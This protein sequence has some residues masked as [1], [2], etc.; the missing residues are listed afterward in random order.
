MTSNVPF[1]NRTWR[2][3]VDLCSDAPWQ[4]SVTVLYLLLA[5]LAEGIGF[6]TLLPVLSAATG[7]ATETR[8][9]LE[10]SVINVFGWLGLSTDLSTLLFV[11]V[12]G[13]AGK[14]VLGLL[15]MRNLGYAS[16]DMATR[17]RV[18]LIRSLM[19][20]NWTYFVSQ[21]TGRLGNAISNEASQAA[22]AY[23]AVTNL[24]ST[25]IQ[26]SI[27]SCLALLASWQV[28]VVGLLAGSLMIIMLNSLVGVARAAGA[29]QTSLMNELVSRLSDVLSL[30]K[31]LKAMGREHQ[32]GPILEGTAKG[33]NAAQR[34]MH[35]A[36]ASLAAFQEPLF[37][38]F[39]AVGVYIILT[40]TNYTLVE[41]LFM[42]V[43]FQR[44]VVRTGSLQIQYQKMASM[45]NAYFSILEAI[46]RAEAHNELAWQTGKLPT[47]NKSISLRNATFSYNGTIILD[48]V[49]VDIPAHKITAL[50]GPSGA[51]KTTLADLVI[52]LLDLDSGQVAVDGKVLQQLDQRLWRESI[53]YV[54]QELILLHD[55]VYMN[56]SLGL[57]EVTPEEVEDALSAAGA[58]DFVNAMPDGMYT[59]VGERGA[60][61]SGGQRQRI[62]LARALVRKPKLLILDEPTTALD[63]KTEH[64]IRET[65]RN[66]LARTTILLIS[67][68]SSLVAVADRVYL[69]DQGQ[70]LLSKDIE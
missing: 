24:A 69:F 30:I 45:E 60:R 5:G 34:R 49:S 3:V 43:L 14:A 51:G 66:L 41:L 27:V 4:I 67:H 42:A 21:P 23:G 11:V 38:V 26:I 57:S 15:A 33:L 7:G 1:R 37:T 68:Q 59:V 16:A 32:V 40:F 58:L 47:L 17:L 62:S 55:T 19:I 6:V 18:R 35:M 22:S 50:V 65:L 70:V 13:V 54:P 46:Q 8:S 2:M 36:T 52:G 61:L 39:L 53:G 29:T 12:L 31:P 48:Q 64:A 56:V 44:I 63:E 28:T 20:S 9:G 10:Q 25:I